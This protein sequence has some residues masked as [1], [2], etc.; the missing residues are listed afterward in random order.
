MRFCRYFSVA[1]VLLLCL[2]SIAPTARAQVA[3]GAFSE[4]DFPKLLAN[5]QANLKA[6]RESELEYTSFELYH[7][8]NWDKSGKLTLDESEKFEN[9]PIEGILY[10][11]KIEHNGKPLAGKEA[12]EEQKRY[13]KAIAERRAMTPEQKRMS[14]HLTVHF[15]QLPVCCLGTLFDNRILRREQWNGRDTLVIESTPSPE[16]KPANNDEKSALNWKE[17]TWI[18]LADEMPV[19]IE[20]TLLADVDPMKRGNS[21]ILEYQRVLGRSEKDGQPGKPVWLLSEAVFHGNAKVMGFDRSFTTEQIWSE[22]KRF[23][24]DVRILDSP[25]REVQGEDGGKP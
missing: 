24:V 13:D 15:H 6:N 19:R 5:M 9:I 2:H 21:L 20:A 14:F 7:N 23:Q 25:A 18:D 22:F 17:T 1:P 12:E 8:Q 10:R 11:H 3:L 4:P 16:A